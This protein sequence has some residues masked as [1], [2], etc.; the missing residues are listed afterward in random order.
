MS[1]EFLD[2]LLTTVFRGHP[3]RER[4]R[5]VFVLGVRAD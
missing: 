4:I 2:H 3:V 5:H 1:I